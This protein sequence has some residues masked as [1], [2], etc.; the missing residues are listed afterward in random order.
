[1]TLLGPYQKIADKFDIGD[2]PLVEL[3]APGVSNRIFAKLEYRNHTGSHYDRVYLELLSSF[4]R[5]GKIHPDHTTLVETTSGNAGISCAFVARERDYNCLVFTPAGARPRCNEIMRDF[6]AEVRE[7]PGQNY[8]ADARDA[9]VAFWR[10]HIK[11]RSGGYRKYYLSNHSQEEISCDALAPIAT[12]ALGEVGE[13]FT[14]FIGAAGNGC[15]LR[16]IGDVLKEDNPD[17]RMFAFDPSAALQAYQ[18]KHG[19]L[20]S[21]QPRTHQLFGTGGWGINFPHLQYAVNELME[22]VWVID[23]ADWQR[24]QRELREFGQDVG[25]TSAAAYHLARDY[26]RQQAHQRVLI[27][28]YDGASHY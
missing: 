28:F 19:R 25:N 11:E 5:L 13:S 9:M 10:A 23:E 17:I 6:G 1:M 7:V 26:C 4:E 16:G 21:H 14:C 18:L 22:D 3:P 24:T 8:I 20:D 27:V 2:T 12:E 15:T